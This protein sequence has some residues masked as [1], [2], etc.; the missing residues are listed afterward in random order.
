MK[1]LNCFSNSLFKIQLSIK[2]KM[3]AFNENKNSETEK[4]DL[5]YVE[6]RYNGV[7]GNAHFLSPAL[8]VRAIRKPGSGGRGCAGRSLIWFS[9][10]GRAPCS[11]A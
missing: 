7:N 10:M 6:A 1:I 5:G 2:R 9:V 11:L 4:E 3:T 8:H